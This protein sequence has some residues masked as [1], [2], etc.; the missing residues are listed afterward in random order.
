MLG[1]NAFI[2]RIFRAGYITNWIKNL[3]SKHEGGS[4]IPSNHIQR[5]DHHVH[6]MMIP[7]VRRQTWG[8]YCPASLA[9]WCGSGRLSQKLWWTEPEEQYLR[10]PP[11]YSPIDSHMSTY[12]S[13]YMSICIYVHTERH[14]HTKKYG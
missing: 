12:S 3:P 9:Y 1:K 2:R 8:A 10:L 13:T 6:H 11:S 14:K 5:L 4:S 7:K